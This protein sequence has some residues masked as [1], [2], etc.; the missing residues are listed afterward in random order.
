MATKINRRRS[1]YGFPTPIA[2]LQQEPIVA[3]RAPLTTDEAEL[4][5]VWV[6]TN[7]N[8]YYICTNN[9]AGVFT[10]TAASAGAIAATSMT[11]NPGDLTLT[12]GDIIVT[13]GDL[14]MDPASTAT[15]GT[16][17]SGNA[18]VGGTLQ[19]NGNATFGADLTVNGDTIIN[20]D[21]DI[22]SA[23]ALS[24]TTTS[25]TDPAILFQTNG[26]TSETIIHQNVQGTAVDAI[27]LDA[28]AG[29]VTISGALAGNA[30]NINASDAAG[31]WNAAYGTGGMTLAGTNG[32]FTVTTGTGNLSIGADAAQHNVTIG[33]ATGTS[34][35]TIQN[36][37]GALNLGAN[38][39][40]HTV[41]IGN[42]TG[43]TTVNIN[44]G[45][46]G[47][48]AIL[49]GAN[50]NDTDITIGNNTASTTLT[51][52][53]SAN[54]SLTTDVGDLL[55]VVAGSML[56]DADSG[57]E[58][59]SSGGALEIGNDAD[60]F[61]INVG[62]GAAARTITRGNVTGATAIVDNTGT[63]GYQLNT[64]GAGDVDVNASNDF[65]V[66]AVNS[67]SIDSA[68]AS[69]VTV[70]G[71]G[72]DL[73]L[74]SVGG[75]LV[76][77]ASEAAANAIQITAS[78]AAGGVAISSNG[79]V[80]VAPDVATVASPTA[81]S[82]QNFRVIRTIFTGFTTAMGASQAFTINS[83]DILTT[84]GT[85]VQVTNLDASTNGAY[86]TVDGVVQAAGSL[87]INCTNNGAGS[88]GAGDNIVVSVWV[89]S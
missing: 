81:A 42:N 14:T 86:L 9:A 10:W 70:T 74:S 76:I 59:N 23:A 13:A 37:T 57:I 15:V 43:A 85:F 39:V 55:G 25:D 27:E 68:V 6:D 21:F 87:V 1:L 34:A 41:N 32:A 16:L 44:G 51:L 50:A 24:F 64:T 2:G 66:D 45:T 40:A 77:D 83:T 69:N 78:D 8:S 36:G 62:T 53:S 48:G 79:I 3:A 67:F 46:A 75:S 71:A 56:I 89:I 72:Q 35:V 88:L 61:A 60:A 12:A 73:T 47:A 11:I 49:I 58:L 84:S 30:I 38:A 29:G 26:G 80:S 54:M 5:V 31:A 18:T 4:G 22:T 7:A 17:A 28:V 82:T 33:S 20:G 63:G 65:L 52:V 19:V